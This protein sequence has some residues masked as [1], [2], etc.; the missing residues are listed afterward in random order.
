MEKI[1][2]KHTSKTRQQNKLLRQ[3]WSDEIAGA[4]QPPASAVLYA[5]IFLTRFGKEGLHWDPATITLEVEE[6]FDVDLSAIALDKLM[7][8]IEILTSDS[9]FTSTPTFVRF[10]NILNDEQND[11]NT[12]D[13]ADIEDICAGLYSA[14]VLRGAP[15]TDDDTHFSEEIKEYIKNAAASEGLVKLPRLLAAALEENYAPRS[16][17]DFSDDPEMFNMAYDVAAGKADEMQNF[18]AQLPAQLINEIT[19]L[20]AAN[21]V[22]H[23]DELLNAIIDNVKKI[24]KYCVHSTEEQEYGME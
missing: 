3:F 22:D 14:F 18:V 6:E 4:K 21:I 15:G 8:A 17:N 10:C 16:I 19:Q 11:E 23:E 2:E 13:P 20:A 5:L 9:F 12:F 24:N 7:C 1:N